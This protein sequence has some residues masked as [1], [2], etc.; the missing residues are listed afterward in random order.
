MV[1]IPIAVCLQPDTAP[2][3]YEQF[4]KDA[5]LDLP[6]LDKIT[7]ETSKFKED[8]AC[9]PQQTQFLSNLNRMVKSYRSSS[10][11]KFSQDSLDSRLFVQALEQ[12]LLGKHSSV[13]VK[14]LEN[15][16]TQYI[17]KRYK[18]DNFK[19]NKAISLLLE[20]KVITSQDLQGIKQRLDDA[21]T[22]FIA[23][24]NWINMDVPK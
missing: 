17:E 4:C 19:T 2:Y 14:Q 16:I 18:A 12:G 21:K 15:C 22:A 8:T 10:T 9:T 24:G 6:S 13:M 7:P 11:N 3:T 20:Y 1:R 5:Q 23:D